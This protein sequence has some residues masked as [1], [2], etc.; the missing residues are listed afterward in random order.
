MRG[1]WGSLGFRQIERGRDG[2]TS[3]RG[4]YRLAIS[5]VC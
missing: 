3:C 1:T 2:S 5:N 4:Q